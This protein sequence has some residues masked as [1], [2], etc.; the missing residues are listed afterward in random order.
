M[1]FLQW[2]NWWFVFAKASWWK[3]RKFIPRRF[4]LSETSQWKCL[5]RSWRKFQNNEKIYK[6]TIS[7]FTDEILNTVRVPL[8]PLLPKSLK[9]LHP[10]KEI[11]IRSPKS[12][13]AQTHLFQ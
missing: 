10:P 3:Q 7:D 6:P 4:Y 11:S 8:T 2:K 9:Q 12:F 13:C 5:N 1:V